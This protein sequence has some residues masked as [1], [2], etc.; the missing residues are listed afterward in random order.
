MWLKADDAQAPDVLFRSPWYREAATAGAWYS[1]QVAT[2][3][4]RLRMLCHWDRAGYI[5]GLTEQVDAGSAKV[6]YQAI[7]RLLGHKRKKAFSADVLPSLRKSDGSMRRDIEEMQARWREHFS[8]LESGISVKPRDLIEQAT[9]EGLA[10]ALTH[11]LG[12]N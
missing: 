9:R 10:L 4:E 3:A 8:S 11:E 1:F 7:H 5:A 6:A 12:D 2:L